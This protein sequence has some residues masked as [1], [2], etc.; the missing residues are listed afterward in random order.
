MCFKKKSVL[1][2]FLICILVPAVPSWATDIRIGVL[3]NNGKE[4][5]LRQ[6]QPTADY[7]AEKIVAHSFEIVPLD[8]DEIETAMANGR[9]E[10]VTA[11]PSLHC[12]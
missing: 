5:C 9:V 7:L 11:N 6:W 3:A 1:L 8:F 12:H 2:I 4:L 10:F